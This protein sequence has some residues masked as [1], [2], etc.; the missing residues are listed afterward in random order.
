MRATARATRV[1]W[2]V[3]V[4]RTPLAVSGKPNVLRHQSM[5]SRSM[6]VAA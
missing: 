6:Y 2:E 3:P 5:T 1:A 4:T